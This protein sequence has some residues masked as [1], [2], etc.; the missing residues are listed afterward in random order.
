MADFMPVKV[1]AKLWGVTERQIA[2]LCRSGR[3]DGAVKQVRSWM[4]PEKTEKPADLRI[5]TGAYRKPARPK[6]LP[7][8]VGVSD[9]RVASSEYYYVD[10]TMMIKDFL[11][12]RPIVSLFTRP[13]RFGKTLNMDML[14]VFFEKT[15]SDTSA[16]FW[17]K[18]I[19]K[20]GKFY[21]EFQGQYPVIYAAFKDV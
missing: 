17:D 6:R 9:Y 21:Q 1:A 20:C 15:D 7:L 12:E 16:Y 2:N 13:R 14:R 8:P 19:W 10:K 4:I 3:I 11:D 18:K 5:K